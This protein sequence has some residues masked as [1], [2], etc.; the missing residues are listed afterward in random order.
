MESAEFEVGTIVGT[1][2]GCVVVRLN[3]GSEILCRG[4]KDLHR[5]LGSY[6][7]PIGQRVKVSQPIEGATRRQR[8]VE[9]IK[10]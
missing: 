2:A 8:I 10:E 1:K 5:K 3:D 7:L 9:F 6:T 4:L